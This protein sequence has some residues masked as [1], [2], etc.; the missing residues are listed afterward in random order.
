MRSACYGDLLGTF[1]EYIPMPDIRPQDLTTFF[2]DHKPMERQAGVPW[3]RIHQ[4]DQSGRY[5]V[6]LKTEYRFRSMDYLDSP[7]AQPI[8]ELQADFIEREGIK[9]IIDCG[10]RHGPVLDILY[11]R[12]Y[13]TPDFQYMG[14]DT[15]PEPIA[16]AQATWAEF[17]N[18]EFRQA[19]MWDHASIAVEFE[20]DCVIWSAIL[21]Y[22][23]D[24]HQELFLDITNNL[25]RAPYAIIQEPCESQ[26]PDY[27]VPWLDLHTID[28]EVLE[29][30]KHVT[31]FECL[32]VECDIFQGRRII[33]LCS[34]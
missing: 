34:M 21:L 32:T 14:F 1:R 19:D 30:R 23:G 7:E 26:N 11:H 2:S 28:S 27:F 31:N 22:A 20:P 25:Y 18:I 10:S 6:P 4:P 16:L 13:I 12:G 17:S 24:R 3:P 29:Y 5:Q 9:R 8:F 15:S 33:A